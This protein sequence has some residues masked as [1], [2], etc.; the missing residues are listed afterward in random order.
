MRYEKRKEIN[1]ILSLLS[2]FITLA[3]VIT[4]GLYLISAKSTI[5]ITGFS[6]ILAGLSAIMSIMISRRLKMARE[7]HRV[8]LIYA[9]EDLEAARKL[10]AELREHGFK[11]WLDIEQITPGQVWQK[12]VIRGLEECAVALV[13]ISE[14][15][16]KKGFVQEEM[17]VALETLQERKKDMS[18]VIPVR[19]DH[20]EVPER[21]SHILWV[22]LFE[23]GGLER[24]VEGLRNLTR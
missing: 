23:E 11:P 5:L 24:L 10:A 17:K 15:L 2:L 20:S 6:A 21:L 19:L 8:F 22:N 16:S 18:P 1:A 14:H 4:A 9:R 12:A 3:G 7:R 13:L